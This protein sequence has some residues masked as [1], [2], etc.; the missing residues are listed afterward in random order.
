MTQELVTQNNSLPALPAFTTQ[1]VQ[2]IKNQVCKGATDDELQLFLHLCKRT[3]LDPFARQI[4]AIQRDVY[5]KEVK[6]KVKKMTF[7]VSIDGLRLVAQRSGSYQGQATTMWCGEDGVWKDVWLPNAAPQAAKAG[8]WRDGFREPLYAIAHWEEYVIQYDGKPSIMWASKPA[9]M[10]AK[11][12]E[13][14]AL[15]RAF[16]QELSGIYTPEEMGSKLSDEQRQLVELAKQKNW[17]NKQV[18]EFMQTQY[19]K[20]KA[21]DLSHDEFENLCSVIESATFEQASK[22]I[23]IGGKDGP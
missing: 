18:Q 23:E 13:A 10:L 2:L 19:K 1:Q 9:L 17:S 15:R 14:L 4:Y 8:V 21:L 22:P 6:Q 3:G 7:Q 12:A 20:S 16:P 5:D 11:C